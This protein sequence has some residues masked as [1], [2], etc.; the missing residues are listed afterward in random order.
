MHGMLEISHAWTR[1]SELRQRAWIAL[2]HHQ[3]PFVP[4]PSFVCIIWFCLADDHFKDK[5]LT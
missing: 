4:W 3:I 5:S 1:R 2:N